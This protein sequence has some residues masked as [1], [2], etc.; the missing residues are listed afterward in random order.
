M[1]KK[2]YCKVIHF[3]RNKKC[4]IANLKTYVRIEKDLR[5]WNNCG[6]ILELLNFCK[7]LIA[8]DE[9]NVGLKKRALVSNQRGFANGAISEIT[10]HEIQKNY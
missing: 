2:E 4:F 3:S 6:K 1:K 10:Y 7:K 9:K 5:K 8:K